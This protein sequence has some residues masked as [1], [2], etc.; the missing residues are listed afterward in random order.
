MFASSKIIVI[1]KMKLR[2][3]IASPCVKNNRGTVGMMRRVAQ[4]YTDPRKVRALVVQFLSLQRGLQ[5]INRRPKWIKMLHIDLNICTR[6]AR[7][8]RLFV[9]TRKVSLCMF[10]TSNKAG[11]KGV[12]QIYVVLE[13]IRPK[14]R[15]GIFGPS[16]RGIK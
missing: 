13:D 16:M 14:S 11:G 15:S 3:N 2:R 6:Q 4:K 12:A 8:R 10:F 1:N 7:E 9:L 5:N